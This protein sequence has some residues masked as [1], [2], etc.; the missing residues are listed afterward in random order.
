M[1]TSLT[2]LLI[3]LSISVQAETLRLDYEGFSIWL[4]CQSRSAI[5]F[6]YNAQRDYGSFKRHRSFYLD[7]DVSKTCQQLSTQSYTPGFDRGHLV[8]A[9]HLD[10]SKLAIKQS[11]YMTN[12]LPMS[13]SLNRGAWYESE[14]IVECYRDIDELLVIGGA[15]PG[16]GTRFKKSH[17]IK[18][19]KAFYKIIVRGTANDTKTIAWLMPNIAGATRDKLD[20]YQVSVRE[21]EIK[22]GENFPIPDYAKDSKSNPWYIPLGCDRG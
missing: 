10:H 18:T 5:K 16:Y 1:K 15:I 13:I 12:V 6:Q 8:P 17:D 19:P 14:K 4:D 2:L 7:P 11:N 9:N 20:S 21:L 22:T 3:F